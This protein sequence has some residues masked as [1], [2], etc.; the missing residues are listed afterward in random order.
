MTQRDAPWNIRETP[1]EEVEVIITV[2]LSKK[3]RVKVDDYEIIDEGV[4]EYG[5]YK[6]SVDFTRCDLER[7]ARAQIEMPQDVCTDWKFEEMEVDEV[8]P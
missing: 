2:V 5:D 1:P 4:D 6:R 8:K 7:A 3:V